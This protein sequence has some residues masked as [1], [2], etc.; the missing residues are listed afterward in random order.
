MPNLSD[1]LK[2]Q[3]RGTFKMPVFALL[4]LIIVLA[5][6][7]SIYEFNKI[8]VFVTTTQMLII[9]LYLFMVGSNLFSNTQL[10][11]FELTMFRNWRMSSIA[12][13]LSLFMGTLPILLVVYIL[14]LLSGYLYLFF[15]FAIAIIIYG[16]VLLLISLSNRPSASYVLSMVILFLFPVAAIS[17]IQTNLQM[18][19]RI[20][21]I[22]AYVAYLFSPLYISYMAKKNMVILNDMIA[23]LL[24]IFLSIM[25]VFLYLLLFVKRELRLS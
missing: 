7:F 22:N 3:L 15:G 11:I 4:F 25:F 19:S 18:G 13:V 1:M 10:T 6:T 24:A 14:L 17:L 12:K 8:V 23:G 21:G 20:A 9:P 16:S 2:W 5:L